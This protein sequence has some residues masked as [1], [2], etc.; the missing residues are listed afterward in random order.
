MMDYPHE[1]CGP[2]RDGAA[3]RVRFFS[4]GDL[5][6]VVIATELPGNCNVSVTNVALEARPKTYPLAGVHG[7]P[8]RRGRQHGGTLA[9]RT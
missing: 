3:F 2:W 9:S 6:P 5:V 1:T 8:T 7:V 4:R